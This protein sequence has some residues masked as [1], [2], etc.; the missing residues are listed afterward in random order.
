MIV[1]RENRLQN[2][3]WTRARVKHYDVVVYLQFMDVMNKDN[4][5]RIQRTD[6]TRRWIK[7]GKVHRTSAISLS[8]GWVI[9]GPLVHC[10]YTFSMF[11]THGHNYVNL[12]T[13]DWHSW[14]IGDFHIISLQFFLKIFTMCI[15][16]SI[17][18]G[19]NN[20]LSLRLNFSILLRLDVSDSMSNRY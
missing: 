6:S 3:P 5:S 13:V 14:P 17:D 4:L 7:N 1:G 16:K 12:V 15:F 8:T 10:A 19:L 11:F 9:G 20:L 2:E 18:L